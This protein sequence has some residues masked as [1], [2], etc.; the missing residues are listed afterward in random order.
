M[1]TMG[2]TTAQ[3]DGDLIK[4]VH[5]QGQVIQDLIKQQAETEE[6]CRWQIKG[7]RKDLQCCEEK[8]ESLL[9]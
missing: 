6:L 8:T 3:A 9:K 4:L 7:L 5:E 1:A 2:D